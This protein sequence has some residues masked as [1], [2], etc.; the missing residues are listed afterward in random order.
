MHCS[1][2]DTVS[3]ILEEDDQTDHIE[4][5]QGFDRFYE[6]GLPGELPAEIL[7]SICAKPEMKEMRDHIKELEDQSDHEQAIAIEKRKYN[8]ALIR[9]RLSELKRYQSHWVRQRR[10][11]RI[12][13]RGKEEPVY[14]ESD[15]STRAQGLIMPEGARIARSMSCTEELSF[16]KM[17]LFV[18]DV[19]MHCERDFDVIYLPKQGPVRGVCPAKNCQL[20]IEK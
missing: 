2:I 7:E 13:N 9:D 17:L 19:Q 8:K 14:S 1:S 10:D 3:A 11:Q 12:L 18:Q 16:D 6:R 4:Y 5:F 15:I 20:P